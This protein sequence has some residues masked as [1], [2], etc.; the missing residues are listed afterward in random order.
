THAWAEALMPDLGWVGFDP[1]NN[2]L[3]GDRHIRVAIGRDY[4]DVPPTR[5]VFKGVS[6]VRSELA[7]AVRVGPSQPVIAGAA[8]PFVP[9]LPCEA[10]GTF[11]EADGSRQQQQ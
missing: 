9:W 3:A 1:T 2:R 7:V 8:L 11:N 6:A 5:G 10:T 4:S